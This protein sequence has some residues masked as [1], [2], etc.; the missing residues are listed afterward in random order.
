MDLVKQE[1]GNQKNHAR[2]SI[3]S[4]SFYDK[5]YFIDED[6][7]DSIEN[8]LDRLTISTPSLIFKENKE[9]LLHKPK[10][11]IEVNSLLAYKIAN[12][13]QDH[14]KYP[15]ADSTALHV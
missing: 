15:Q 13:H 5:I 12:A 8:I 4:Y 6:V 14:Q 9:E 2:E 3:E 7:I 11:I 10:L 1:W